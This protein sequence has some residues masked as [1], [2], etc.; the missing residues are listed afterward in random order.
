MHS[1]YEALHVMIPQPVLAAPHL[2]SKLKLKAKPQLE[3]AFGRLDDV[4]ISNVSANVC[5]L[6]PFVVLYV[7]L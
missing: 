4:M 1:T 2:E 7:Y 5:F 3:Q 6:G